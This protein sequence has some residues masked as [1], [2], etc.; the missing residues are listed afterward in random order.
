MKPLQS[1][2]ET[3]PPKTT[4]ADGPPNCFPNSSSD[5]PVNS[6]SSSTSNTQINTY[7]ASIHDSVECTDSAEAILRGNNKNNN[8]NNFVNEA[9]HGSSSS[10]PGSNTCQQ[11]APSF[12]NNNHSLNDSFINGVSRSSTPP[13]YTRLA[14][15]YFQSLKA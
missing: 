14:G 4:M 7:P 5:G 2:P 3:L 15:P 8:S 6:L 10:I 1:S 12:H 9:Y 13:T 11:S